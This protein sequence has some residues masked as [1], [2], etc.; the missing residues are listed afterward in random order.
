MFARRRENLDSHRGILAHRRG[1]FDGHLLNLDSRRESLAHHLL[2]LDHYRG[3]LDNERGILDERRD[4]IIININTHKRQILANEY[5]KRTARLKPCAK[6][7]ASAGLSNAGLSSPINIKPM[8][9]AT[10]AKFNNTKS[11]GQFNTTNNAR[12]IQSHLPLET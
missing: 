7:K 1:T 11:T 2:K 5:A 6:P 4:K 9:W 8:K 12:Q 10:D 3:T